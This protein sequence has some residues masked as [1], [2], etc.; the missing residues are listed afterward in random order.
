MIFFVLKRLGMMIPVLLIASVVIFA[1]GRLAPGDPI[2]ILLNE[3][4]STP[5]TIKATREHY[6]LDEPLPVQYLYWLKNCLR[7]DLGFSYFRSNR[8][9]TQIIAE[10]FPVTAKLGVLAILFAIVTGV[11]L[12][13]VAAWRVGT[14]IDSFA[15]LIAMVGVSVPRFVLAPVLT[16]VLSV[17]LHLLPVAGW[18]KWQN[19][20]LPAVVLSTNAAAILC[21]IT[22]SSLLDVMTQD[23]IRTAHAKGLSESAVVL[24]H[25]LKNALIPVMTIAGTSFGFLLIGSFIVETIFNIPGLGRQGVEAIFQRDYPVIQGVVLSMVLVFAL[26]NLVVDLLYALVD[27]RIKYD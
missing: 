21:R 9:V 27:P 11:S 1:M 8:K 18:G 5:E 17:M 20:I 10:G 15:L 22:R 23:Y 6:G 26:I 24:V 19:Y 13:I 7:G 16:L 2:Q 12:G 3:R 14:W 4:D 25:G